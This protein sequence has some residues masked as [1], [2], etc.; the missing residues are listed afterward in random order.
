MSEALRLGDKQSQTYIGQQPRNPEL[1][2]I[3]HELQISVILRSALGSPV[4]KGIKP[5][6]VM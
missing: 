2:I 1:V 3:I 6:T 4:H 5:H